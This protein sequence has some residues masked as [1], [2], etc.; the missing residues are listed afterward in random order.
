MIANAIDR[1]NTMLKAAN[2]PLIKPIAVYENI[3]DEVKVIKN[4]H[5]DLVGLYGLINTLNGHDYVGKSDQVGQRLFEH[6]SLSKLRAAYK[7][8]ATPSPIVK[9]LLLYNPSAFGAVV[10]CH[11][12]QSELNSAETKLINVLGT[13]YNV[14]HNKHGNGIHNHSSESRQRLT[15]A[16][17]DGDVFIYDSFK[18]LVVKA[19]ALTSIAKRIKSKHFTLINYLGKDLIFRG[20]WYFTSELINPNDKPFIPSWYHP[21]AVGFAAHM[22]SHMHL[23]YKVIFVYTSELEFI[24]RWS[25]SHTA[26][27]AF[28]MTHTTISDLAYANNPA[29]VTNFTSYKGYIFS[30]HRLTK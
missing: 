7:R 29:K 8:Y 14:L 21:D 19:P 5:L 3:L 25:S 1:W 20:E 18:Q 17:S 2:L 11:V 12:H 24:G 26:R 4:T 9:A 30:H 23:R 22:T 13:H 28:K 27:S 15:E 6:R 10:I 16:A